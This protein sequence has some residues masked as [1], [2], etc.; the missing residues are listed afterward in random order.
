MALSTALSL[1][2]T[3]D[4]ATQTAAARVTGA[5]AGRTVNLY[6]RQWQ[7]AAGTAALTLA[8]SGVADGDGVA[9][10]ADAVGSTGLFLWTAAEL[11]A[12]GNAA[13]ALSGI[14]FHA[15]R[16]PDEKS[17]WEQCVDWTKDV[18][19]ALLLPDLPEAK[20]VERWY[21]GDWADKSP[22]LPSVQIAPFGA[23]EYPGSLNNTDDVGYPVLVVAISAADGESK[24]DF[25]R[26]LLWRQR[27]AKALRYRVP[28][29][30]QEA[31]YTDIRPEVLVLPDEWEKGYL[32]SALLFVYR[33]RETRGA[34]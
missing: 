18:I 26:N 21:P 31:Y 16:D 20:C 12:G 3:P 24:I 28:V 4:G 10:I 27:I 13:A 29:G 17:V 34:T 22:E 6:R 30:I 32:V 5:T 9:T 15:L 7:P 11:D 19:D 2:V 25:T 14:A 8:G 1:T 23:E 33:S